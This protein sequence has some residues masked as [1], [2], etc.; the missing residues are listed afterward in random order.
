MRAHGVLD[1]HGHQGGAAP[2]DGGALSAAETDVIVARFRQWLA[3]L[4]E[5]AKSAGAADAV[6]DGP[7]VGLLD[8]VQAFTALRQEIK[9]QTRGT[10]NL[11]EQVTPALAGLDR[12]AEQFRSVIPQEQAAAWQAAQPLAEAVC[13]LE[14]A[15]ER[16][17]VEL[18][19]LQVR[20]R[21]ESAAASRQRIEAAFDLQPWWVRW[22]ASGYHRHVLSLCPEGD[23]DQHRRLLDAV[24]E[25]Y[26]LLMARL[27]RSMD[28]QEIRRIACLGKQ[29]DPHRMRVIE[30][31]KAPDAEPGT[32]VEEIRPGY[33]WRDRVLRVAEV[34]AAGG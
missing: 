17:W 30:L 8:L 2:G 27:R 6:P 14:E 20:L 22:L 5:E 18:R 26:G 3:G 24:V 12:A 16:V 7:E 25:G 34:C 32:V 29:L 10:R 11:A 19:K 4:Q 28:Q 33:E 21:Q 23:D 15:I 9:L 1:E 31:V 13:D